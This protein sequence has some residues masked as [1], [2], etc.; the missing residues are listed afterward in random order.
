[1]MTVLSC[2]GTEKVPGGSFK[3]KG[4]Q[5]GDL[6]MRIRS[7]EESLALAKTEADYFHQKWLDLKLRNE[8]LG[9]EAL[10]ANEKKLGERSVRLLGE[11]FRSE[12]KRAELVSGIVEYMNA[13]E[14]LKSAKSMERASAGAAVEAARRKLLLQI[15]DGEPLMKIAP[16][17]N[18]AQVTLF[19]G[20]KGMLIINVGSIHGVVEG[21][22]FRI[23]DETTVIGRCRVVEVREYLSAAR[24]ED[25]LENKMVKP[26]N[27]L[28]LDTVK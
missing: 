3:E 27:R 28:Y 9:I 15:E 22:P 16:D 17:L 24:L 21:M 4:D 20:E 12:K 11:L 8:A 23:M 18:A 26:G 10:T 5:D 13:V 19:D 6:R 25:L 14:R 7:L 1:M 2:P